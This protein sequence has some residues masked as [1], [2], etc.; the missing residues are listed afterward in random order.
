MGPGD[1]II[2]GEEGGRLVVRVRGSHTLADVRKALALP[3]LSAPIDVKG[4]IVDRVRRKFTH[5]RR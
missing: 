5:E 4:A 2:W 1:E 3:R